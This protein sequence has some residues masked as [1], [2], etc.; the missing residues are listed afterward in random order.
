M[1]YVVL[2]AV[3]LLSLVAWVGG[4]FYTIACLRPALGLLEGPA[5]V[6]L[7]ADVLRRFFAVVGVG[8]GFML[9]SGLW[10]LLIAI[11]AST[12][13][14]LP[15]NMPLDWH[16]MIGLGLLMVAIFG[17]I[18]F[19]PYRRLQRAARAQDWPAGAAALESIRNWVVLNLVIGVVVIVVM[20]VGAAV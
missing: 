17:Q 8:I 19:G 1:L 10:M 4:M 14:G 3:H 2:K 12:A 20:R 11:R 18:R 13:P 5:R 7:M 16:V 15:F 6:R 9:V